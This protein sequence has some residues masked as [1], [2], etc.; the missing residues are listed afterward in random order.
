MTNSLSGF[1]FEAY[2]KAVAYISR[3]S[4]LYSTSDQAYV[5]YRFAEKLFCATTG[6]EDLSARDISFD[7]KLHNLGIGIKTFIAPGEKVSKREKVAEFTRDASRGTFVGLDHESLAVKISELRNARIMSDAA[8]IGVPA[9]GGIYH[10]LVRLPGRALVHEEPYE[11]I[12][13]DQIVPLDK[14]GKEIPHFSQQNSGTVY[15]SDGVSAYQFLTA[16]N[17]LVKSFDLGKA[18]SSPLIPTPIQDDI[19]GEVLGNLGKE[20][21]AAEDTES[22]QE[23]EMDDIDYVVLPLYS[24]AKKSTRV[25]AE[26]SGINQWNAGG[27]ERSFGEAYIPVPMDVHRLRPGFFPPRDVK[28][29]L[30]LPNGETVTAKLCQENSKALM[31]DPNN[32]LCRWLFTM[33]DGSWEGAR[34]RFPAAR[35]YSYEDLSKIGKDSVLIRWNSDLDA[36]TLESAPLGAY[37]AFLESF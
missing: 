11:Q 18:Y 8:E 15:F 25:V 23:F 5:V 1:D 34:E 31:S 10:C 13:I 22:E 35:P 37:E 2:S 30:R 20:N 16:K 32:K 27:R 24:T 21:G 3:L 33:I 7:A 29:N 9:T 14:G 17:T 26:K 36:Y 12:K 28:F 4:R 6:A 19:W